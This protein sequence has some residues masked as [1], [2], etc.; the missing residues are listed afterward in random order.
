MDVGVM[1]A[2]VIK[3]MN[4]FLT[5]Y[6]MHLCPMLTSYAQ[7]QIPRSSPTT[8][9][10]AHETEPFCIS[11]E[12]FTPFE[13]FI[14]NNSFNLADLTTYDLKDPEIIKSLRLYYMYQNDI[15]PNET[16]AQLVEQL[17]NQ[18]CD[19]DPPTPYS[20]FVLG[21]QCDKHDDFATY[22]DYMLKAANMGINAAKFNLVLAYSDKMSP[23][24][25]P[26]QAHPYI[27]DLLFQDI[28]K[29]EHLIYY[30]AQWANYKK[31]FLTILNV[32][33][34]GLKLRIDKMDTLFDDMIHTLYTKL[35]DHDDENLDVNA[36]VDITKQAIKER[37]DNGFEMPQEDGIGKNAFYINETG[38]FVAD[39]YDAARDGENLGLPTQDVCADANNPATD[40][41]E[42]VAP[43]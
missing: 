36:M 9:T 11:R 38:Y 7:L 27:M 16:Y 22:I 26:D 8:E 12:N 20:L 2:G 21:V 25:D 17:T 35:K 34:L 41:V 5:S 37:L 29:K 10:D 13:L 14:F 39:V 40:S 23:V 4:P 3:K 6:N 18:I 28:S 30:L 24:Y 15:N 42:E 31:Y 19:L 32:A 1:D 33:V 43:F